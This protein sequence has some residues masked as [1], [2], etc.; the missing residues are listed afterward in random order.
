MAE[1]FPLIFAVVAA[2]SGLALGWMLGGRGV[3]QARQERD[4]LGERFN[5]AIRD[6]AG[7]EERARQAGELQ[8]RLDIAAAERETARRELASLKS[9]SDERERSFG[10]QL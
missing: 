7:A 1:I 4:A 6:L 8:A 10:E 2:F 5:A 3:A 9:Q